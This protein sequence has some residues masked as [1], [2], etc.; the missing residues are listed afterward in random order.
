MTNG[1]T[2]VPMIV[3]WPANI[4]AGQTSELTDFTDIL[5]T[6]AEAAGATVPEKISIDGKSL[7][8]HLRG[9]MSS[10]RK[11]IFCYYWGYGRDQKKTRAWVRNKRYKLYDDGSFYDLEKDPFEKVKLTDKEFDGVKETLLLELKEYMK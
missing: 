3:S 5:P 6:L 11:T 4:K 1:G 9:E 2:H 10:H 7:L 8:P